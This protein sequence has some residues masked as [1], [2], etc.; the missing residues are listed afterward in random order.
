VTTLVQPKSMRMSV[1]LSQLR[2]SGDLNSE[3]DSSPSSPPGDLTRSWRAQN[4]WRWP[5]P[6][7]TVLSL[8]NARPNPIRSLRPSN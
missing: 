4:I 1:M 2:V 7:G 8:V 5:R 6:S 3:R